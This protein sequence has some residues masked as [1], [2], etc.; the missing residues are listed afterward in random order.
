MTTPTSPPAGTN[1]QSGPTLFTNPP[2]VPGIITSPP[3]VTTPSVPAT[4]VTAT[5]SN[6][7]DVMVYLLAG[8]GASATVIKVN[9]A[10]TGLTLAA[11]GASCS[12]Y[13]PAG[14]TISMTYSGG[15]LTW[16]WLAV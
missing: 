15:T 6:G 11:A 4:T 3:A 16:V 10:T 14:Q 7:V 2:Q 13:L 9:G 5:N 1:V 12:V 8:S